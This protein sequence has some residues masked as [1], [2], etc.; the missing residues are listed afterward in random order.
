VNPATGR[1]MWYDINRNITYLPIAADRIYYGS[2]LATTYGGLNNSF[3]YKG[4][5]LT[6]FFTYEYGA[7]VSDG[8]Y[9]FLRENGTRLTLNALREVNDRSWTTPGQITDIP[10]NLTT[11]AGNEPRGAGRNSGS[12]NL[13][14]ADFI[15]LSQVTVG[16]TFNTALVNRIGL[17]RA[18]VYAQGLNL[19]TYTDYPGYDPEFTGAGT[20]QIPL[21][22]NYTVGVQ[23]GF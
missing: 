22:K 11:N 9:N 19:W 18:R 17:S 3:S 8:Q 12:A 16:Y 1:P 20:G 23:I 13:L 15:R 2:N 10:R 5:E 6:A 7:I 21:T 14:K 4:F